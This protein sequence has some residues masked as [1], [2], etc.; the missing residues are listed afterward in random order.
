[1]GNKEYYVGFSMD[2]NSWVLCR[3][4]GEGVTCT[5]ECSSYGDDE[6]QARSDARYMNKEEV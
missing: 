4:N 2:R 6:E 3:S 1:M 5:I